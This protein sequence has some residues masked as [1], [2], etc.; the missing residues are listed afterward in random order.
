MDDELQRL[1]MLENQVAYLY[2][3]LGLDP[4]DA[5][6]SASE[7][8]DPEVVQLLNGGNKIQAIKLHRE[9]TGLGLAEAKDAVEAFER[10]YRLG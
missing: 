9:R 8:L 7:G 1:R 3:H 5:V 6:P 10:R 2:R 4:A